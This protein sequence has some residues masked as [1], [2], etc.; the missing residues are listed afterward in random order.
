[1]KDILKCSELN[2]FGWSEIWD[3][4]WDKM[5]STYAH[6]EIQA[7]PH[8]E[9][10][11]I[12]ADYGQKYGLKTAR[13][14]SF[15]SLSGKA[16]LSF[17]EGRKPGVGDW[18]VVKSYGEYDDALIHG[19]L[20]RSSIISRQAAGFETKEQI[21][22]ANVDT[23]FIVCALNGDYNIRRLERYLILAW[24]SGVNPVIVLSKSDLCK[25]ISPYLNETEAIA[26][27]VPVIPVSAQ[28]DIGKAALEVYTGPG[29]TVALAGSSGSGKSTMINWLTGASSQLT[30]AVREDD[31]RGR[32]TTTHREM[33]M[34]PEGGILI[35]TP[36]MRTLSIWDDGEG[37]SRTFEDI[38]QIAQQCRFVDCQHQKEQGCAVVNA[39]Q[40]G[41]LD[42][43]RLGNYHKMLREI[44]FQMKKEAFA[45]KK[46]KRN[47][48]SAAKRDKKGG[49]RR[50]MED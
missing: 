20:E 7:E 18:V 38:E 33:F 5:M 36:G 50:E 42:A 17:S 49:W 22:A 45:A 31:S 19:V 12:V 28:N 24:N 6:E 39:V 35:D 14:N 25:D 40:S 46:N 4:K 48:K 27:G 13:G 9:P 30:Q 29:K 44:K 1:M 23:L 43:K 26:P 41:E 10:A 15:G 21:I 8:F 3:T 37:V 11:R 2:K 16:R 47:V 32:H 34:L